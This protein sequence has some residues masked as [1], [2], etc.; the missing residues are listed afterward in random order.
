MSGFES[1]CSKKPPNILMSLAPEECSRRVFK[2]TN[3]LESTGNENEGADKTCSSDGTTDG[4]GPGKSSLKSKC[5]QA[6]QLR[7]VDKHVGE[8]PANEVPANV[9]HR[10]GEKQRGMHL[11]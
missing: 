2:A 1:S 10:I 7:V 4:R 5:Q 9:Q 11:I 3:E 8:V 6:S